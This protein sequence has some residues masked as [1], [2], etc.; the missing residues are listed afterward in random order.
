M[1]GPV[2][3]LSTTYSMRQDIKSFH[4]RALSSVKR[5]LGLRG[6]TFLSCE[7]ESGLLAISLVM[8]CYTIPYGD[9]ICSFRLVYEIVHIAGI[10]K[11]EESK[12]QLI[13]AYLRIC[14]DAFFLYM[15]PDVNSR[16][17]T[18]VNSPGKA[19]EAIERLKSSFRKTEVIDS[20]NPLDIALFIAGIT[21]FGRDWGSV[22]ALLP[23]RTSM[24]LSQ[25]YYSVWKGSRM[26]ISWKKIR[27]QR[28]LE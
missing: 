12:T 18:L 9:R 16:M 3:G 15:S 21:R 24:E 27:K 17:D 28:G 10:M 6:T 22:K 11:S 23:H 8:T 25:F 14:D 1:A 2:S 4:F 26:Y 20:W 19:R 5:T 7:L 13:N